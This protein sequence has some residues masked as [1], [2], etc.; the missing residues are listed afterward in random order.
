MADEASLALVGAFL[1]LENYDGVLKLAGRFAGLYPKS[2]YLDSFQ[3]SEALANFHL[4]HYERAVLVAEKI[5]SAVYKDAAGA[6]QP[7]PNKWQALYILGQI[8]DA[9]R[10]PGK[11]LEY[12]RQVADRFTD[13]A[14]AIQFY[15]RKDLK[16]AEVSVVRPQAKP[17]V[18]EAG[19]AARGLR[20]VGIQPGGPDALPRPGIKLEYRNVAKA[21]VTVYPVDLMQLYLTR[22][23]LNAI[24]GIDLAGITPLVEKSVVLGDGSDYD[25][26][27]KL[28]E[29]PLVKEGAYLVM[30]RGD[31]LYTSGI[32]LVSP[33][34]LEVLEEPAAGRVRIS[35]RDARSKEL[36]PKV[37]VK[38]IGSNNPQFF[39][40]E[41]DL[42]G[43]YVAEGLQ[44]QVSVVVRKEGAEY[45]FHRG[46]A[47]IGQPPAP[48]A[49][50]PGPQAGKAAN[51]QP[52]AA[53]APALNQ[54]LDANLKMQNESNTARQIQRL[55]ERYQLPQPAAPKGAAAGGFR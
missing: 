3:Y 2:T 46:S 20:A 14:S 49:Q 28:I 24:A 27:S 35:V 51:Q 30:I 26:R 10:T 48:L 32:V 55:Q 53:N 23:N 19:A 7:S 21:D 39:S 36:L 50:P 18:A 8:Y 34:E 15:T 17:A 12:Y 54:A 22:R 38:A 9:R 4:G 31:N 6:D 52:A 45:A 33:L 13:A 11:A 37:Q 16:V 44:G 25:D 1:E 42:R 43:V 29:L 5:V 47:F 41:T 40:G